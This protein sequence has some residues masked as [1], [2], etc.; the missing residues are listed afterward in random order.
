MHIAVYTKTAPFPVTVYLPHPSPLPHNQYF[1]NYHTLW[2]EETTLFSLAI[3]AKKQLSKRGRK[4]RARKREKEK[5][6]NKTK[7]R[8]ERR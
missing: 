7:K 4:N 8:K 1:C 3:K 5:E 6:K 2:L